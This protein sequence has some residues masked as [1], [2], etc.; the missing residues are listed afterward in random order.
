M[1]RLA[2]VLVL[3]QT[4]LAPSPLAPPR[5]A[6]PPAAAEVPVRTRGPLRAPLPG[7]VRPLPDSALAAVRADPAYRYDAPEAEQPSLLDRFWRWVARTFLAP[8]ARGSSTRAGQGVWLTVAVLVLAAVAVRLFQTGLGGVFGRRGPA[9]TDGADPL[10]GVDDIAAVD[11]AGLLAGALARDDWRA[12]VRLRFLVALQRLDARG[13]VAWSRDKTNQA[14][15]REATAR[16][17]ADVGRALGDVTRAFESVWYGGLAVDAARWRRVEA[18]FER[19]DGLLAGP[20]PRPA[21]RPATRPATAPG[22]A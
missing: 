14:F 11:L 5:P 18:R 7:A 17:G 21:P 20:A 8:L 4:P 6:L 15:V 12:A 22:P 10:L 1:T 19:L 3:A 13:T 16:G 2:L 9:A